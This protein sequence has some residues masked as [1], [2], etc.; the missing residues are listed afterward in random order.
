[1]ELFA[2]GGAHSRKRAFGIAQLK[3]EYAPMAFCLAAA[4]L[5]FRV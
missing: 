2:L 1:V 4:G 3:F 5:N